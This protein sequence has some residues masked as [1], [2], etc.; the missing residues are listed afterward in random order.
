MQINLTPAHQ[1]VAGE[2]SVGQVK[3]DVGLIDS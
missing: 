2:F 3:F 1:P